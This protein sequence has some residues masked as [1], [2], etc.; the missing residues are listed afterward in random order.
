M[1]EQ[2]PATI[3]GG[4]TLVVDLF[5]I[6]RG[7]EADG[8]YLRARFFRAAALGVAFRA[9]RE[10]SRLGAGLEQFADGVIAELAAQK[11]RSSLASALREAVDGLRLGQPPPSGETAV[12]VC[13]RCGEVSIGG[14][15]DARCPACG[16]GAL[17]RRALATAPYY[18]SA[19]I[20]DVLS[21]LE[22]TPVI[23]A[24]LCGGL[25]HDAAQ[26]GTWP[27]TDILDHL[28]GAQRLIWGR[29]KRM[30]D[31]DEP[32]LGGGVPPPRASD[33]GE[34]PMNVDQLLKAFRKERDDLLARVRNLDPREL[35]TGG[36]ARNWGRTTVRQRL[37]YL[38]RHEHEHLG[39]LVQSLSEIQH[40]LETDTLPA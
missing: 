8:Q 36:T 38:A 23:C 25:D 19:T 11:G 27:V 15:E 6:A 7:L 10:T 17:A 1:A 29:A 28:V 9:S 16:A 20:G 39:D 22:V 35:E 5:R 34:G 30:L 37:T 32:D 26:R 21:G 13:T 2:S 4:G 31:E 18:D 14:Q 33:S 40:G 3:R 12:L 24:Q